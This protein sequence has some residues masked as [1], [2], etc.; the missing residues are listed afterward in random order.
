MTLPVRNQQE[1]REEE[2][3][4]GKREVP[5]EVAVAAFLNGKV[6]FTG[7]ARA[8]FTAIVSSLVGGR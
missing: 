2:R 7:G 6:G 8:A 5:D 4:P 3:D 1:Q